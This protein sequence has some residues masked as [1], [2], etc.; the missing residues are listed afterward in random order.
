MKLQSKPHSNGT[1]YS[2][3]W[4]N[5]EIHTDS[6]ELNRHYINLANNKH[7]TLIDYD[8]GFCGMRFTWDYNCEPYDLQAS[9][10]KWRVS[11]TLVDEEWEDIPIK[12][13]TFMDKMIDEEAERIH[14][15]G[16]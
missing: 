8:E 11:W 16:E 13:Y 15:G 2:T 4:K 1:I 10:D 9:E 7:R 12:A 3:I 5:G 6:K 14:K